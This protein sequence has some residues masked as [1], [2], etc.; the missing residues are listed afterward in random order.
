MKIEDTITHDKIDQTQQMLLTKL[1]CYDPDVVIPG[2]KNLSYFYEYQ[3]EL[4]KNTCAANNYFFG[5]I[6]IPRFEVYRID[7]NTLKIE[8]EYIFGRQLHYEH[9]FFDYYKE[10][11]YNSLVLRSYKH[12]SCNDFGPDNFILKGSKK[13]IESD[14]DWEISYVDLEGFFIDIS[15]ETRK[16]TFEKDMNKL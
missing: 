13:G 7:E 2:H 9:E 14:V 16:R 1:C 10:I 11:I 15:L 12:V 8:N 4:L 5:Q 3:Y 6:R